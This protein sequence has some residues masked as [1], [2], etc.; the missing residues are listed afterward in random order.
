MGCFYPVARLSFRPSLIKT[1][2]VCLSEC[3]DTRRYQLPERKLQRT[4]GMLITQHSHKTTVTR[5]LHCCTD[6]RKLLPS[7][8][9]WSAYW[10]LPTRSAA[11]I[12]GS[13]SKGRLVN[14]EHFAMT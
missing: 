2:V 7:F 13:S 3:C 6:R 10:A 1:S 8:I 11:I 12:G 14:S 9:E 5:L 4:G